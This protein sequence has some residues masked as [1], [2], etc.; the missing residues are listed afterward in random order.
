MW[1]GIAVIVGI[2]LASSVLAEP[3][4]VGEWHSDRERTMNFNDQNTKLAERTSAFVRSMMGRLTL[5]IT[6]STIHFKLPDF[7]TNVAGVERH[8]VGFDETHSY[9]TLAVTA[10]T[11][12]VEAVAPITGNLDV[13]VYNFESPDVMWVYTGGIGVQLPYSHL[14]EYFVRVP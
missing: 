4:L 5:T 3:A 2:L 12:V 7:S 11:V 1:K 14:R 6:S 8:L 13:T 9:R 10:R